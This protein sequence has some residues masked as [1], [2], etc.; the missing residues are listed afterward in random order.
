VLALMG[1]LGSMDDS[2]GSIVH[3]RWHGII[4]KRTAQ[5]EAERNA[6]V[7]TYEESH[8][9][10]PCRAKGHSDVSETRKKGGQGMTLDEVFASLEA[11]RSVNISLRAPESTSPKPS[12]IPT[13]VEAKRELSS[14][15]QLQANSASEEQWWGYAGQIAYWRCL[16]DILAAV[17][18]VGDDD[19]PEV[20]VPV[21]SDADIKDDVARTEEFGK[22]VLQMAR[23]RGAVA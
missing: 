4:A 11:P 23:N 14:L 15:S 1:C 6:T 5:L 10:F 3:A 21:L 7:R 2:R 19:L 12:A 22:L 9:D 20:A 16:T 18:I 13:V 17:E 8:A